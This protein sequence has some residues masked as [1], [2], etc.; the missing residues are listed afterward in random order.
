MFRRINMA[1]TYV[2]YTFFTNYTKCD[3]QYTQEEVRKNDGNNG[4]PFWITFQNKVYD[5]TDYKNKHPGGDFINQAGGSN[6]EPFWDYWKIHY[7]NPKVK[8]ILIDN[9]IGSL[10]DRN[11][12]S[13]EDF[14]D[15][16]PKRGNYFKVFTY[17]PYDAETIQCLLNNS[18]IT[19]VKF[20]YIRNHAP[21]PKMSE[22]YNILFLNTKN[23]D[24]ELDLKDL[25]KK[26][27]ISVLQCAGNR[28]KDNYNANGPN[29]FTNTIYDDLTNGQM[30]NI[31]WKGYDLNKL[32]KKYYPDQ[33]NEELNSSKYIW[34]VKFQGEDQFVS[35]TPLKLILERPSLI[36]THANDKVLTPDHGYP[37][38]IILPGIIGARNVKWIES[39]ELSKE[40]SDSPWNKNY[41]NDSEGKNIQKF[42]IQSVILRHKILPSNKILIEGV[43]YSNGI[44]LDKVEVFDGVKWN[45]TKLESSLGSYSWRRWSIIL[46][47]ESNI[48]YSR[49]IDKMNNI[50]SKKSNKQNGYI[51]NGYGILEIEKENFKK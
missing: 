18:Q 19:P 30:G 24:I 2:I 25:E 34:H 14:Y 16:Q 17:T 4:K 48:Y 36:A 38:R 13:N 27:I 7:H 40:I 11:N 3:S 41:Y 35:S 45:N 39:I 42:P 28:Q 9:E 51:Y 22:D 5:L 6:I 8:S 29:N 26:E 10:I 33:I 43:A 20:L 37:M 23:G 31:K 1:S 12:N 46:N 32:L 47:N 49:A 15:N 44:D 21:V 50:Q